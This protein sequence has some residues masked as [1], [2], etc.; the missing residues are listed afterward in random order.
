MI[1]IFQYLASINHGGIVWIKLYMMY[2]INYIISYGNMELNEFI[3]I[4]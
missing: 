4:V 3:T 1:G 2:N